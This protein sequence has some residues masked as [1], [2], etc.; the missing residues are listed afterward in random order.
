MAANDKEA[1]PLHNLVKKHWFKAAAF[2]GVLLLI[3]LT[4]FMSGKPPVD[5]KK[6]EVKGFLSR[7]P[8]FRPVDISPPLTVL[9]A[10]L[11]LK[12]RRSTGKR[13]LL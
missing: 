3:M 9:R 1:D 11:K 2:A 6:E 10:L 7:R 12:Q 5:M 8:F 4:Q 13:R